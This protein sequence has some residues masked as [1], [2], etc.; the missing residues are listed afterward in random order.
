MLLSGSEVFFRTVRPET[1][2]YLPIVTS[3]R[4][5]AS[6]ISQKLPIHTLSSKVEFVILLL[7]TR[8]SLPIVLS[9]ITEFSFIIVPLPIVV[10]PFKTT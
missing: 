8:Q 10:L 3:S 5:V 9:Q 1:I 2:E 7:D 6:I 4:M